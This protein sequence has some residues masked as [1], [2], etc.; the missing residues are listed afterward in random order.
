MREIETDCYIGDDRMAYSNRRQYLGTEI[1][2]DGV[3]ASENGADSRTALA[4]TPTLEATVPY[5][6][7]G[8]RK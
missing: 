7:H 6:E 2:A 5:V 1:P 3:R 4:S 8:Q